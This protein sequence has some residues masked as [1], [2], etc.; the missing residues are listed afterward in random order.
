M[1]HCHT[2]NLALTNL[3][4]DQARTCCCFC[5]LLLHVD[6]SYCE[7]LSNATLEA[8]APHNHSLLT[9]AVDGCHLM[10]HNGLVSFLLRQCC[11]SATWGG[12]GGAGAAVG[13]AAG[14]AADTLTRCAVAVGGTAP[15]EAER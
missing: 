13:V 9:L 2:L 12:S 1:S 14:H 3:T 5:R 8:L 6:F 4:D 11:K 10:D 7:E 15:H